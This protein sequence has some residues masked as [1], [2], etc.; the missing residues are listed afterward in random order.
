MKE[1]TWQEW[2]T[3]NEGKKPLNEIAADY[4]LYCQQYDSYWRCL[5][6]PGGGENYRILQE[7]GD[8]LLQE[9]G[10]KLI[11]LING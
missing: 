9:N 2:L 6:I 8:F 11:W 10:D 3:E 5:V 4:S 1:I 7:N